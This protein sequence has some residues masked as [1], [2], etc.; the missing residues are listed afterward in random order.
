MKPSQRKQ[1]QKQDFKKV[2]LFFKK[3]YWK[4]LEKV[5]TH[6]EAEGKFNLKNLPQEGVRIEFMSSW[7]DSDA[8]LL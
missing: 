5:Q 2:F 6:I 7:P 3:E 1:W 4:T 8:Q